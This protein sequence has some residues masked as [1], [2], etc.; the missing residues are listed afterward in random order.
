MQEN[1]AELTKKYQEEMLALY[2]RKHPQPQESLEAVP[3]NAP[4]PETSPEPE[5]IPANA[6]EPEAFP[7]PEAV[8]ANVPEPETFPEPEAI[9][10][11]A[12]EPEV[13]SEQEPVTRAA[14]GEDSDP[15]LPPYIQPVVM[16]IPEEW[17]AQ[18]AYERRNTAEGYLRVVTA[19]AESAYPVPGAKV[20]VFTNIGNKSNLS[21]LLVTDESGETP[22]VALPAPEAALSQEPENAVPYATCDIRIA[23]K[24]YFKTK[25]NNVRIFAGVTTRQVFQLVPLPLDPEPSEENIDPNSV[26]TEQCPGGEPC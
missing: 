19:T 12:P 3:A 23:A 26:G 24:G 8:P 4:E 20:S 1:F 16:P 9:P 21:Y 6:P 7:E 17:A 14:D 10:A 5:A 2:G 22:T 11:N 18:E 25:A 15:E 13:S